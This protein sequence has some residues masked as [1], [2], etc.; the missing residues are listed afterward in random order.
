MQY[1]VVARSEFAQGNNKSALREIADSRISHTIK[2][3]SKIL[4]LIR[5]NILCKYMLLAPAETKK[6]LSSSS[7][8]DRSRFGKNGH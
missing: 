3:W 7:V 8:H 2:R 1:R 5:L 6:D 4:I